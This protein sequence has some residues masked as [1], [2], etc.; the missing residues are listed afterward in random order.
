MA[1]WVFGPIVATG[2]KTARGAAF[3]VAAQIDNR[4][5]LAA[6]LCLR[7]GALP[8]RIAGHACSVLLEGATRSADWSMRARPM[9]RRLRDEDLRRCAHFRVTT[10][11]LARSV[12]PYLKDWAESG[13]RVAGRAQAVSRRRMEATLHAV[14]SAAGFDS[15]SL[16]KES[17]LARPALWSAAAC[18]AMAVLG[19]FA[20]A[21]SWSPQLTLS[22]PQGRSSQ[23]GVAS[24]KPFA[25]LDPASGTPAPALHVAE[26]VGVEKGLVWLSH[27]GTNIVAEVGSRRSPAVTAASYQPR[28]APPRAPTRSTKRKQANMACQYAITPA[29]KMVCADRRLQRADRALKSAY[30]RALAAGVPAQQLEAEHR[31][32]LATREDAARLS[33]REVAALYSKRTGHINLLADPPY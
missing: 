20:T 27:P 26:P 14:R 9:G 28:T 32:W 17:P 29:E 6:G 4:V 15:F 22:P 23:S 3:Q 18:L 16:G 25:S 33:R 31:A 5:G 21:R 8:R 7:S 13:G 2:W 24:V 30:D 19:V 10:H 1:P 11:D 12:L